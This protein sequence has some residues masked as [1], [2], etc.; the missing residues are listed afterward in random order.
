MGRSENLY[1]L[2]RI[3]SQID[4][5]NRRLQ[6]IQSILEDDRVVKN[7]KEETDAAQTPTI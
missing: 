4:D 2:Q 6:E 7:A 3:D 1:H 5:H